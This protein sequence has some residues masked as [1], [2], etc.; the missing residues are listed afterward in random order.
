MTAALEE[1]PANLEHLVELAQRGE[2]VVLTR[3][4]QP[5][6]K[7]TGIVDATWPERRKR[8][9]EELREMRNAGDTGKRGSPTTEEILTE[10]REE[11]V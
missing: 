7:I 8:W 3:A 1:S 10:M 9:L 4:G 6:A 11:R 2:E 5:V